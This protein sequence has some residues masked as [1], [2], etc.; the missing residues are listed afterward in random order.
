MVRIRDERLWLGIGV[1][2]GL[3]VGVTF[4]SLYVLPGQPRLLA[5]GGGRYSY[6]Q[7]W[8][9]WFF[10]P[11]RALEFVLGILLAK[12]VLAG[13]W[14][15]IGLLPATVLCLAGYLMSTY[16]V[17]YLFGVGGVATLWTAPLIAAL[18]VAD[19]Q[20]R[21]SWMRHRILVWFGDISFALY[22][23][24]WLILGRISHWAGHEGSRSIVDG[25][26]LLVLAFTV[27]TLAAW[28][29]FTYIEMPAVRRLS[30]GP[31]QSALAVIE[32]GR[33]GILGANPIPHQHEHLADP[34][35]QAGDLVMN[36]VDAPEHEGAVVR[37]HDDR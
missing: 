31:G 10:P 33:E 23:I 25:L 34:Q 8:F 37:P 27:S 11:V 19:L 21:P 22:M 15:P 29:M 1:V 7:I 20:G 12:V 35:R 17:P 6:T 4:F 24:H 3:I 13:R 36:G 28:L 2:V 9:V 16:G 18:A 32:A 5:V 30:G 26:G 14:V